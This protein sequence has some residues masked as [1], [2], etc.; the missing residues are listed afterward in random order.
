MYREPATPE[1]TDAI[2]VLPRA[3]PIRVVL[4]FCL[5]FLCFWFLIW[6]VA[7]VVSAIVTGEDLWRLAVAP[8]AWLAIVAAIVRVMR[9][10]Q[11]HL[12]AEAISR[13]GFFRDARMAWKDVRAFQVR[14]RPRGRGGSV[15][16]YALMG[17]QGEVLVAPDILVDPE[18]NL[19]WAIDRAVEGKLR[20]IDERVRAR[21]VSHSPWR[22]W[23]THLG[24]ATALSVAVGVLLWGDQT[25][26][27]AER[28]LSDVSSAPYET[29]VAALAAMLADDGL[30]PRLRCR[31]GSRLTSAAARHG[32]FDRGRAWC[33]AMGPVGCDE[34]PYQSV[35]CDSGPLVVLPAA[36]EA[37]AAGDAPRAV[38]LLGSLRF[39]GAVRDVLEI[40]AL[41]ESG[42]PG[43]ARVVAERC[44]E[45]Y[46]EAEDP[47][48]RAFAR[49]CRDAL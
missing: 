36:R 10:D 47:A 30:E 14:H 13:G 43:M 29:K 11:V 42:S 32:D 12:G 46:A 41:R 49:E 6:P 17:D 15:R 25:R 1:T 24:V 28:R 27:A 37:L 38:A 5:W 9:Y 7:W 33:E 35:D 39:Q 20:A 16:L 34:L 18:Q 40:Q 22:R 21:G 3:R 2:I 31:A 19:R 8:V 26:R 4:G 48:V 44:V 45:R 23:A